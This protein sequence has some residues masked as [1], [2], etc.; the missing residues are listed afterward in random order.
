M[1][2]AAMLP[3]HK[4]LLDRFQRGFPLSST[5]YLDIA[6]ELGVEEADVLD[7]LRFLQEASVISRIGPVF[8]HKRAGSS[9]LAAMSVPEDELDYVAELV[10]AYKE[11]NHN[12]AR[13]HH[14]NLWFVVTASDDLHL[15]R[16]LNEISDVAG[17]PIL[18][19]PME[20]A[21]HID[22]SFKLDWS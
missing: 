5:P 17:Y 19:L 8:N 11:V 3:L 12:Y 22:L 13:E 9:T 15:K 1:P 18:N 14:Y 16:T 20:K 21:Y 7:A 6:R 4:E 2:D 10:N